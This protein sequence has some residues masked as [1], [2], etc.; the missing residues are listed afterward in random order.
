MNEGK[1]VVGI[2]IGTSKIAVI[3][4][5]TDESTVNVL[6]VSEAKSSGIKKGQIVD[7]EEAVGSINTSLEAAERMAGYSASRV[8]ASI[9][10]AHIESLN[11]KGV[12][13]VSAPE[14]EV[15]KS[16]LARVIDAARAVS[17]PSSREIIH[18]LP[19]SYTVDGQ[20][21]IKDPIG[22]SGIR[23][24]VDTH[25]ISA[26]S[27]AIRNLEKALTEVGVDIDGVVYNGYASSL[28][29]L[30][31]TERELGVVLVDIGAGTTE[32]SIYVEGS[33]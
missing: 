22:M 7:I 25:I 23:L 18:V 26:N 32:I 24:E 17:L 2:D 3:I 9:G 14:G 1:I 12:V 10:G 6:G 27:T 30:S 29:S 4:A 21:G 20:E 16:D 33:V 31:E 8:V 5:R 13:A 11:S 15:T 19:R 28:S